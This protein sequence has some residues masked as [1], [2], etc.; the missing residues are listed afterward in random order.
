MRFKS[1]R[2]AALFFCAYHFADVS[3]MV[4]LKRI[5]ARIEK[6]IDDE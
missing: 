1:D 5:S 4:N 2:K 3:K 6:D